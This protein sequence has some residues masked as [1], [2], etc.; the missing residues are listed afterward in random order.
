MGLIINPRQIIKDGITSLRDVWSSNKVS[1]ELSGKQATLVSGTNIKTINNTSLLG[2]GDI[3]ISGGGD[4]PKINMTAT[5]ATL[6]PNKFYV[7]GEVASLDITLASE[8]V[9]VMNVYRFQ[10]ESGN[11]PVTLTL[12]NGI[13]WNEGVI[14]TLKSKSIFIISI[15]SNIAKLDYYSSI[16]PAHEY[17]ADGLVFELDGINK[18][19]TDGTWVDLIGGRVYSVTS[20][21]P[22]SL[23]DCWRFSA[24]GTWFQC[25]NNS[26]ETSL[27]SKCTLEVCCNSVKTM[28]KLCFGSGSAAGN[29]ALTIDSA[30]YNYVMCNNPKQSCNGAWSTTTKGTFQCNRDRILINGILKNNTNLSPSFDGSYIGAH[31]ID[32]GGLLDIYCVRIYNRQLE[33]WELEHNREADNI[34]FELG[35]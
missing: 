27:L 14:P 2:S 5:T 25:L 29:M 22:V 34:R 26:I 8:V 3:T 28:P 35:L 9:G 20:G 11:A 1:T 19:A 13:I 23:S 21:T 18:G 31:R 15:V 33:E 17:I 30:G 7:W 16:L 12:P 6:D 4:I 32:T 10:F 24:G